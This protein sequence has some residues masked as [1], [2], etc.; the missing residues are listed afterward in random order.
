MP[1]I[2]LIRVENYRE[3]VGRADATPSLI[4]E[5]N[6]LYDKILE[7]FLKHNSIVLPLRHGYYI[8][9]CNGI[10]RETLIDIIKEVQGSTRYNYKVVSV[11]HKY[12]V[13][14]QLRASALLNRVKDKVYFENGVEDDVVVALLDLSNLESVL[15][16][17]SVYERYLKYNEIGNT[18]SKL[19][20][21]LGGI[22]SNL[23]NEAL[24]TILPRDNIREF[25]DLVP[26]DVNVGIG[27]SRTA[28]EAFNL[29]LSAL[30]RVKRSA[31]N[32]NYAI[33][34]SSS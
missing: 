12:P 1:R 14:A 33:L 25:I 11:T 21:R 10:M 6:K 32:L 5:L 27:V 23:G 7:G 16:E 2:A 29:A 17:I 31:T 9:I 24:V 20:F 3:V 13:I 26:S 34:Y 4:R 8:G 22:T 30:T 19:A 18:V 28:L 15:S